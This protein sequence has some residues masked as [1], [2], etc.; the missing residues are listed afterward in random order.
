MFYASRSQESTTYRLTAIT[1]STAKR[2]ATQLLDAGCI[3]GQWTCLT[4][5]RPDGM[6][7]HRWKKPGNRWIAI[8]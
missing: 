5:C 4:E 3:T 1:E 2:E 6:A 7:I 8:H